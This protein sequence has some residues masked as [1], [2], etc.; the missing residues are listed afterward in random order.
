MKDEFDDYEPTE[1]ELEEIEELIRQAEAE[2]EQKEGKDLLSD[3]IIYEYPN[4]VS[5]KQW[6]KD[7]GIKW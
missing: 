2:E 3:R 6:L 4:S 7:N 5:F 1:D